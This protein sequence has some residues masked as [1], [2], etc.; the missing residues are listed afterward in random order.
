MAFRP[1]NCRKTFDS[2]KHNYMDGIEKIKLARFLTVD[3]LE[4]L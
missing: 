3:A 2:V 1:T 4:K